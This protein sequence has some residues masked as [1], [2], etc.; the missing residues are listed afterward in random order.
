LTTVSI[1]Q[2]LDN[3]VVVASVGEIPDGGMKHVEAN[4]KEFLVGNWEGK[5]Y[6]ISD[7]CGH[8]NGRLSSGNLRGNEVACAMHG[9]K[10]DITNGKSISG[11]QMAGMS[12]MLRQLPLPDNVQKAME[13][14]G[15]LGAE[16]KTYDVDRYDVVV[17][18]DRVI[19]QL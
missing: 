1:D 10:Y 14:Q 11:P 7:R 17:K 15:K 5:Y 13:R 16:I 19:L 8:M 12:A 18:E 9:A 2:D 3:E 6:A 4:G